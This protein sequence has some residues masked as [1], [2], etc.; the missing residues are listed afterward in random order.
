MGL[1]LAPQF[2]ASNSPIMAK[3]KKSS[4]KHSPQA[5]S[6]RTNPS[7]PNIR[8][9]AGIAL[10]AA[11]ALLTY[12]P[13]LNGG[14]IWDDNDLYI[15]KNQILKASDGLYRFCCTTEPVEYHPVTN[16]TFWIEWRLWGMNSTGY[17]VTNLIL[18][19]VESLLIWIIL[20]KLSIPGA[21][22][23]AMIFAVHPVNVESAA[24]IAE[25]KDMMA[26]L[27]FLLSILCYLKHFSSSCDENPQRSRHTLCSDLV[28]GVC[29][30]HIDRW[31]W[32]SLGAFVSA[33]LS[34]G[35]VAM[36]PMILLGITWWLRTEPSVS[37]WDLARIAPFLAVAVIL[38]PVH[39]WFQT[40]V[41]GEVIRS[42][43]FI[44]RLLGAGGVVWFYLYK[45]VLPI[46]LAFVY[47]QWRIEAGN[48]LWWLP[49]SAAL[50]VTAALWRY[51][52][53]WSRPLLFAWGFFCVGLIPVMG[54]ADAYFMLYSLVAD[55]YQHIA[56]VGVIALVSAGF[57]AWHQRVRGAIR[58]AVIV[59]AILAIGALAFLTWRQNG[60]YRDE[61]TLYQDVLK[62]NP[63]CWL[64]HCNLGL[65]LDNLGRTPEAM[66]HYKKALQINP[67]Y[68]EAHI[69]M[70]R[71]LD[72]AGRP[73]EALEHFQQALRLNPYSPEPYFNLGVALV[74]LGR[75]EQAIKS[76]EQ[77]L[78]LN[79][80][81]TEAHVNLGNTLDQMGQLQEAIENFEQALLLKPDSIEAHYNLGNI[82][83]RT[84]RYKEAIEHYEQ[85]LRLRPNLAYAHNNLGFILNQTGRFQEAVEHF[86]QA[87]QIVPDS[88]D[89]YYNLALAY[90]NMRQSSAARATAQKALELART[91]GRPDKAKQIEVWLKSYRASLSDVPNTLPP[92]QSTTPTP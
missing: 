71:V 54:F 84:G 43:N 70:G 59:L 22:L 41:L 91:Q 69:N 11:A 92:S 40:H 30:L 15:T 73:Q 76:Y 52:K 48:P 9:A 57:A 32:L 64:V 75:P 89:A 86:N 16:T 35:S 45:A 77:A 72:N 83:R 81:Y 6:A 7:A 56:I 1:S 55:H 10:I 24:W 38:T 88:V 67:D 47:P 37:K 63:E 4:Q 90:A 3:R 21:F 46:N 60:L 66:E 74:K 17:H 53:G 34:K 31:Y 18:H 26:M 80:N 58:Q 68:P 65:I 39:V 49:L 13:S 82:L 79:P 50:A 33:M 87:I 14:F 61:I 20:R 36:L 62:K 27:F 12:F 2:F 78:R 25:R 19:I 23:A 28:H 29:G 85:V 44:E 51:R 42:A 5:R 8:F